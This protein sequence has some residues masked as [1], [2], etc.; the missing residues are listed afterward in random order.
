MDQDG[1]SNPRVPASDR[2]AVRTDDSIAD[3]GPPRV[4]MERSFSQ[5]IQEG[6]RELKEAAEQTKNIILDLSLDGR[7]RWVSPS[8]T[9]VVGTKLETVKDKPIAEF[10]A[11]DPQAFEKAVNSLKNDDSKSQFVKFAVKIPRESVLEPLVDPAVQEHE[12]GKE[13]ASGELLLHLEGQGIMVYD[14]SSGN[15]SHV[16]ALISILM[17]CLLITIRPCGCCSPP[18]R[19]LQ[20]QLLCRGR[21]LNP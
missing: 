9:D 2:E 1:T 16:R 17:P 14:R 6:T 12:E 21:W 15:E 13:D 20:S 18:L 5:D 10:I 11:D 4:P 3:N 19:R 8:W 7:I